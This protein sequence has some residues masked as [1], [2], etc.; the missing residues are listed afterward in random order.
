M[1]ALLLFVLC[2]YFRDNN[3]TV[4]EFFLKSYTCLSR[5]AWWIDTHCRA[6]NTALDSGFEFICASENTHLGENGAFELLLM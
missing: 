2:M 3:L 6:V 4:N 5:V 1:K